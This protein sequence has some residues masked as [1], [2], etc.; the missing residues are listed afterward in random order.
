MKRGTIGILLSACAAAVVALPAGAEAAPRYLPGR[1]IVAYRGSAKASAGPALLHE[2]PRAEVIPV[3]GS[4]PAAVSRLARDPRV[5]Y[6]E[7]DYL[8]G[9]TRTVD[10][11]LFHWSW[12]LDN[13]GQNGGFAGDDIGAEQAWNITM[14]AG[15][16][17][18]I[19][20]SGVDFT[21]PDLR[22]AAVASA[23]GWNVFAGN[24]DLTDPIGHGTHVAGII[25]ARADNQIGIAGVAPQSS[26]MAVKVVAP[27]GKPDVASLA[28]GLAYAGDHGARVVNV[29]IGGGVR[30]KAVSAA[31]AS[32]PDTL[33]VVAAGND[34]TNNDVASQADW[35]CDEPAPNVICVA[36]S[37]RFDGMP[38][39][40]NYGPVSVDLAAPGEAILSTV[41]RAFS[42]S[43][44][45]LMSGTS[46][47]APHVTGAAA[48][49]FAE[50]PQASVAA[51]KSALLRGV[52]RRP[53][54]AART[55]SGGRL[56]AYRALLTLRN[57]FP[58]PIA[59]HR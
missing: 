26:L 14:G 16:T 59:A 18:G 48:L 42:R 4:V 51:V 28:T 45:L 19:T 37:N 40:S 25:G 1:V 15:V 38:S 30:S 9:F 32:H 13:R 54:L 47:A 27:N 53:A 22:G 29:S 2:D 3:A 7:P 21:N 36:A 6:A 57:G 52:D 34:G 5:A 11:P 58:P 56:D 41:P 23:P 12:G 50:D 33:Y 35:P 10:D 24:G 8:Y 43:G 20:D 46:M 49:L 31:I 39:W 17:V 55:V 44:Y